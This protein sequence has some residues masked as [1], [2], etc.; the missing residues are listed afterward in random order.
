MK[1]LVIV[2]GALFAIGALVFAGGA[3][4]PVAVEPEDATGTVVWASANPTPVVEE[5]V[6]R[7]EARYPQMSVETLYMGA[8]ET[9]ARIQA[10]Q[11]NP[12]I[13]VWSGGD[14]FTRQ[15]VLHLLE[16][17][18]SV[19]IDDFPAEYVDTDEYKWYGFSGPSQVFLVNT[20]L[21]D[22]AD[23]PRTWSDLADPKYRG[24]IIFANPALSS[25]AFM[26]MALMYQVGGWDLV[27]G[28]IENAVVT[29]SS[30]TAWQTVGD[31]EYAVGIASENSPLSLVHAGYPVEVIFPED[32]TNRSFDVVS[33]VKNSPNP[34]GAKLLLDFINSRE[35]HEVIVQ[36]PHFRR[37]V[38]PDVEGIDEMLDA[39]QI[40]YIEWSE[41]VEYMMGEGR[42][43]ML[44]TFEDIFAGVDPQ[45]VE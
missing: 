14:M 18:R 26:Q 5:I 7:F 28:V 8:G 37:S 10:E 38:R 41:E 2:L 6:S 23:Y 29:P 22:E 30:R 13:D 24:E 16:S 21:L 9:L 33:I 39:D 43:E 4:E 45:I 31:G 11:A 19:H 34:A 42:D 20:N 32:G 25:S 12:Q 15:P 44:E 17:Y 27:R 36:P 3:A 35:A 1:R 40:S